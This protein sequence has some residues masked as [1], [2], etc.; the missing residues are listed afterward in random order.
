MIHIKRFDGNKIK[1]YEKSYKNV[2]VFDIGYV[3]IKDSKYLKIYSVN[4]LYFIF[5]KVNGYLTLVPTNE[6]KERI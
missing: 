4:P 6:S 1:I 2:L 5:S 3:T